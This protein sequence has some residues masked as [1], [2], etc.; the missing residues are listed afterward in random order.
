[1]ETKL[2]P[3][4]F[5]KYSFT[6]I[7]VEIDR[8]PAAPTGADAVFSPTNQDLV[9]N[10]TLERPQFFSMLDASALLW[11]ARAYHNPADTNRPRVNGMEEEEGQVD[12]MHYWCRT[13][14]ESFLFARQRHKTRYPTD[15]NHSM[16]YEM[17]VKTNPSESFPTDL[18]GSVCDD[19]FQK[20][21]PLL[22]KN[23]RLRDDIRRMRALNV[24]WGDLPAYRSTQQGH[25]VRGAWMPLAVSHH[26]ALLQ[27]VGLFDTRYQIPRN[28]WCVHNGQ[29]VSRIFNQSYH[30]VYHTDSYRADH[31]KQWI[32]HACRYQT[33]RSGKDCYYPFSQY[34]G[35]PVSADFVHHKVEVCKTESLKERHR[36]LV[37]N[38]FGFTGALRIG[39]QFHDTGLLQDLYQ[40]TYRSFADL[41]REQRNMTNADAHYISNFMAYARTHSII[42]LASCN[43]GTEEPSVPRIVRN[44][45]RLYVDTYECMGPRVED[46]GVP[47]VM[48]FLPSAV[49]RKDDR[50]VVLYAG[51][52]TCLNTKLERFC[53]SD[54]NRNERVCQIY[55]Q[56]Y[57]NDATVLFNRMLRAERRRLLHIKNFRRAA[58]KR[59]AN[60]VWEDFKTDLIDLQD[61]YIEFLQTTVLGMLLESGADLNNVPLHLLE[62]RELEV[63]LFEEDENI[64]GN[65]YL[66]PATRERIPTMDFSGDNLSRVQMAIL[67]LIPPNHRILGTLK[68]NQS[69]QIIDLEHARKQVQRETIESNKKV[70][71]RYSEALVSA[72]FGQKVLEFDGPIDFS[73]DM[74][75]IK[76]PLLESENLK[77]RISTSQSQASSSISRTVRNSSL[78]QERGPDSAIAMN[79]VDVQRALTAIRSR[80]AKDHARTGRPMIL[81]LESLRVPE[82]MKRMLRVEYK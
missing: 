64:L 1:M 52:L 19:T 2:G 26:V 67:S 15:K 78:Q 58:S 62:P 46:D 11:N 79:T 25:H 5:G 41:S 66:T 71:E 65:D 56:L 48:G 28:P 69:T 32:D 18:I 34:G 30:S 70:W 6:V 55:K 8:I 74:S 76:D 63:S 60:Y 10:R 17:F 4:T 59:G 38:R 50:P 43:Q 36:Q 37:Y 57:L 13:L 77:K 73:F 35:T 20:L 31:F 68:L 22:P 53:N 23:H 3:S 9:Y 54:A 81:C 29:G 12:S 75:A 45:Y 39:Q 24:L 33:P 51:S 49:N 80:V 61:A 7:P 40:A 16:S 47:C 42:A 27:S 44:L 82:H 14:T 21:F 72:A